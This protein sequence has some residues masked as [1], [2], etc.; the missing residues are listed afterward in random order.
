MKAPAAPER[1]GGVHDTEVLVVGAGPA[2]ASC[3]YWLAKA[4]RDVVVVERKAFPRGKACGDGLTP[5][6]V[7]QLEEMGLGVELGRHHR[8][9]GLRVH[10]FGRDL[11][12]TWPAVGGL[13]RYG[14]VVTRNDLDALVASNAA[15]AGADLWE[16]TEAT[17]PFVEEGLLRGAHL[18][19]KGEGG[20]TGL[21]R[22]R[23]IVVAEGANSRFGRALGSQRNKAYPQG[24]ALRGY[25]ES[26]RH[27]E[28]WIDSWLDVRDPVGKVV[29]GYGWIFPLGDGRVNVGVGLLATSA[30]W[31]GANTTSLL[32]EFC[33]SAPASWGIDPGGALAPLMGGWLPMGLAVGPRFGP[34]HLVAGDAA[35]MINP[36]NGEGIAYGYETGRLAAEVLLAALDRGRAGAACLRSYEDRLQEQYGLYFR[37]ARAFVRVISRPKVMHVCAS[38]GMHSRS[39]MEWLMRVMANMLRPD[40]VGP[41][42]AAYKA[43]TLL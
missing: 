24:M 21:V 17:A 5:R 36:F 8:F 25:W 15:K 42:E 7:R 43:I 40:E 28:A 12:L 19:S 9:S 2:G 33:K 18:T 32:N 29:P 11:E 1:E 13:P 16:R 4:G 23:Y 27:G 31:K 38:T 14:Y 37:V 35:G 34:T 3:A 22:A 6:S 10:G 39:F 20:R 30:R 26:P 41:A